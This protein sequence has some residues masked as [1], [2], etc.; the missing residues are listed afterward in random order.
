MIEFECVIKEFFYDMIFFVVGFE[1]G[2]KIDFLRLIFIYDFDEWEIFVDEWVYLLKEIYVDV[3]C[4][5]GFGDKGIDVVG[6][7]DVDCFLGDW[8]NYQCKYYV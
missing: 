7:M 5:I 6:F 4:L 3:V 1:D 8:D 2:L